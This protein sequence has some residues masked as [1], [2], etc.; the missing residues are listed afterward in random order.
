M[1]NWVKVTIITFLTFI[2]GMI[3]IALLDA[4]K[5]ATLWLIICVLFE[6]ILSKLFANEVDHE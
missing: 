2:S 1:E 5:L 6:I 3:V 4:Y